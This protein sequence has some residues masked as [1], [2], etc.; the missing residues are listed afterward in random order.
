MTTAT[1]RERRQRASVITR[2]AGTRGPWSQWL[3][4]TPELATEWLT[5]SA[6]YAEQHNVRVNRRPSP[7]VIDQYARDMQNQ[8]WADTGVPVII[9][10][11]GVVIDGQQRLAA[12][13]KSDVTLRFHVVF[14][15]APEAQENID[16]GRKR[17]VGDDLTIRGVP[18]ANHVASTSSLLVAWR[19]GRILRQGF[20]P[21][22]TEVNNFAREHEVALVDAVR[23]A[24]QVKNYVDQCT[25]SVVSACVFTAR[26]LDVDASERFFEALRTGQNL[27]ARDPVLT[28]RNT[29]GR[30]AKMLRKPHRHHQLFQ[31]VYAWNAW[32]ADREVHHIRVPSN[33]TSET[34]PV[35]K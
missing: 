11:R 9:D 1:T 26:R 3:D 31:V 4:V 2:P 14:D 23:F 18:D 7:G 15:V 25:V 27:D 21:S 8:R 17:T 24:R 30:Y 32:R 22:P 28:L 6:A 35:M 10:V 33:L 19:S 20:S 13:V 34:F 29:I 12:L 16:K 5:F